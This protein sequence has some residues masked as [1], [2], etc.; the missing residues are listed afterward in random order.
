MALRTAQLSGAHIMVR[1]GQLH[2][3]SRGDLPDAVLADLRK[4]RDQI[5]GMMLEPSIESAS[6]Y[7]PWLDWP[8]PQQ[9][10]NWYPG[11]CQ[12]CGRPTHDGDYVCPRPIANVD[13]DPE[14]RLVELFAIV[15]EINLPEGLSSGDEDQATASPPWSSTPRSSLIVTI[16]P[17]PPHSPPMPMFPHHRLH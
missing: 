11:I 10:R 15:V 16:S 5:V 2:V 13:N 17:Q 1:D 9:P 12:V 8:N 14:A 4:Y 7:K 3:L 6:A